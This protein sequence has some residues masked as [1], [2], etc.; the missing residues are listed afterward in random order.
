MF[1]K[2]HRK[3]ILSTNSTQTSLWTLSNLT[4]SELDPRVRTNWI[5]LTFNLAHGTLFF[6]CGL[7][8]SLKSPWKHLTWSPMNAQCRWNQR[9]QTLFKVLHE[10]IYK[11]LS[12]FGDFFLDVAGICADYFFPTVLCVFILPSALK[13]S[14]FL[15]SAFNSSIWVSRIEFIESSST[16]NRQCLP[17]ITW[18]FPFLLDLSEDPPSTPAFYYLRI[19]FPLSTNFPLVW[20]FDCKLQVPQLSWSNINP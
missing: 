14:S 15:W 5:L 2:L 11:S 1:K 16:V 18:L 20:G 3:K 10:I 8:A 6:Q 13:L 17:L 19:L 4:F 7:N 9:Q 12:V